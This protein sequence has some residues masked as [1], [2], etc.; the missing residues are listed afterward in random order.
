MVWQT[1]VL[2][3]SDGKLGAG[4]SICGFRNQNM[5][6][7]PPQGFNQKNQHPGG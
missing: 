6:T 1:A 7:P 2:A 4:L 5:A 3:A